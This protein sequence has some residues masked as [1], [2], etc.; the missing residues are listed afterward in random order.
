MSTEGVK[1]SGADYFGATVNGSTLWRRLLTQGPKGQRTYST[2]LSGKGTE[3]IPV[4]NR[5]VKVSFCMS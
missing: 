2:N 4:L 1:L 5:D 3:K